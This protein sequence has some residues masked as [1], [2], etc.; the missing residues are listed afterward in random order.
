MVGQIC[1][2]LFPGINRQGLGVG[3][4][5][6]GGIGWS[7]LKGF[8]FSKPWLGDVFMLHDGFM[9]FLILLQLW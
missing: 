4:R 1:C 9:I 8:D 7:F 2:C 5:S 6:F 3:K